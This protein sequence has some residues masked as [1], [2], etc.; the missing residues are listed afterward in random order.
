M[1]ELK[2]Y[3]KISEK[4]ARMKNHEISKDDIIYISGPITTGNN[5]APGINFDGA[6][7]FL[8][9]TYNPKC[10]ISPWDTPYGLTQE[11]YMDISLAQIR[12]SNIM[13]MLKHWDSSAG[14]LVEHAYA[15]KRGMKIIYQ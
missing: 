7:K 9:E 10:I 3:T 1:S 15:K 6:K 11:A 8:K 5:E 12:A 4:E 14:A 13:F 2:Q